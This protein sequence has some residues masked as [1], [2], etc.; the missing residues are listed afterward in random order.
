ML[1]PVVATAAVVSRQKIGEWGDPL[2]P[3]Q[4]RTSCVKYASGNWPWG[5]GWKSCVGW[6]TEWRHME[7]EMFL[8]V[9][10]PSNLSDAAKQAV[11][12]CTAVGAAAAVGAGVY[13]GGTA[14]LAAGKVAFEACIG[15]KAADVAN[16]FSISVPT[17]SHWTDWS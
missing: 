12:E 7:V 1:T 4:S 6:K 9:D 3:P 14:A 11:V 8:Q 5:G 16:E 10:G 17:Q 13:S 15:T 2:T